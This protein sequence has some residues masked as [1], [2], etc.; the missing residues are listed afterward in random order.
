[1]LTK[2]Y[3]EETLKIIYTAILFL[4]LSLPAKANPLT[5]ED[6]DEFENILTTFLRT[7]A[8]RPP[9]E[10]SY[11]YSFLMLVRK[12]F[13]PREDEFHDALEDHPD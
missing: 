12:Y 4:M 6:L 9:A 11:I 7:E 3:T 13:S 1:M 8:A 10:R 5:Q 2:Q